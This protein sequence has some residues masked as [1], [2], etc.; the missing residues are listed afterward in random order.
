[1]VEP[2][3]RSLLSVALLAVGLLAGCSDS[4]SQIRIVGSSTVFPFTSAVA[5]NFS[6]NS[7]EFRPPIVEATGTGGGFKLFCAGSGSRYP[8]LA[9][10]SRRITRGELADCL[11]ND[12]G[13]IVE[14][15]VG[16]DG[17]VLAQGKRAVAFDLARRDVY[18]ALAASPFGG[19]QTAERWSDVNPALPDV[20]IEVLGP[21]P[22]SGTRDSFNA[23]FMV[24]GCRTD[25]AM[26]ELE[27]TDAARFR[28]LCN[29]VREDGHFVESGEN[30]NL[31]V[32][33]VG[34]SAA[35]VGVFGFSFLE[36]NRDILRDV[37][38]DGVAPGIES[39][40]RAE[41]PAAR[42]LY[43][44]AKSRHVQAIHGLRAF[45][46]EY[47]SE[48]A[49]GPGGYLERRGLIPSPDAVRAENRRR[50]IELTALRPEELL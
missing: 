46:D 45:L 34:R 47:S 32:Q 49:W 21:P 39:I 41:Y 44:Y 14:I 20:R 26:R 1:M 33:R 4:R 6:R 43:I 9:N 25:P 17:L 30:D 50:A 24:A 42:P 5:E 28:T 40:A 36:A 10:A 7:P 23:L 35:A 37:K 11:K 8:D 19:P 2:G 22:T 13:D 16:V 38:I 12:S 15:K 27:K 18:A 31:V 29:K 48:R 3:L